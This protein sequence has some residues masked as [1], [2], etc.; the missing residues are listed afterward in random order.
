VSALATSQREM[1]TLFDLDAC[2]PAVTP[3]ALND[4]DRSAVASRG[5]VAEKPR[6]VVEEGRADITDSADG[7]RGASGGG[8][9]L[10]DLVAGLWEGLAARRVVE[11]PVCSAE[12]HP[13]Y[14]AHARPIG[15]R[16]KGCGST[17][18]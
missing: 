17:L 6:T 18:G 1:E 9:R 10:D 12:M 13:E 14:G 2:A 16:C 4:A 3:V 15:G 7:H 5:A 8:P 11:C